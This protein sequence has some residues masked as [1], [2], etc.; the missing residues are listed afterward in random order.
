MFIDKRARRYYNSLII[1]GSA[2]RQTETFKTMMTMTKKKGENIMTLKEFYEKVANDSELQ[3]KVA[4]AA[5]S[6]KPLEEVLKGL[7]IDATVDELKAFVSANA[8]EG[9]LDKAQLD[10]VAGGTT[11]TISTVVPAAGVTISIS[12]LATC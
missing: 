12:S 8:A 5:K 10:E 3:A 2:F 9:K 1:S 7:G 11:P 6:G 4:E